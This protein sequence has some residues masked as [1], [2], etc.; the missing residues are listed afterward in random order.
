MFFFLKCGFCAVLQ[1]MPNGE[2]CTTTN[3]RNAK[4]FATA[5]EA[6]AMIP[7]AQACQEWYSSGEITVRQGQLIGTEDFVEFGRLG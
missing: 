1:Q 3:P 5:E 6:K 4:Q 2:Y 7:I